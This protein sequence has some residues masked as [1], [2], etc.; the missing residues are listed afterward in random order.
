MKPSAGRKL[1]PPD[2]CREVATRSGGRGLSTGSM[3]GPTRKVRRGRLGASTRFWVGG[4]AGFRASGANERALAGGVLKMLSGD[5][6]RCFRR[7]TSRV[8]RS[9]FAGRLSFHSGSGAVAEEA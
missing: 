7:R 9:C 8:L 6:C 1:V 3:R 2:A 5:S 4:S